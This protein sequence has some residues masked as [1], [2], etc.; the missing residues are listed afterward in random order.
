MSDD[1]TKEELKA[2]CAKLRAEAEEALAAMDPTRSYVPGSGYTAWENTLA[3][4]YMSADNPYRQFFLPREGQ[5][6]PMATY[7]N[8]KPAWMQQNHTMWTPKNKKK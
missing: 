1:S 2:L 6:P 4:T 3:G 7:E 5:Q 8:T